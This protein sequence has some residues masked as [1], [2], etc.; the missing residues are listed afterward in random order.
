MAFVTQWT[1]EAEARILSAERERD[2][3]EEKAA[4]FAERLHSVEQVVLEQQ[5]AIEE[6]HAAWLTAKGGGGVGACTEEVDYLVA[7]VE[8]LQREMAAKT[9]E[10]DGNAREEFELLALRTRQAEGRADGLEHKIEELLAL[11]EQKD[12]Q[13]E[14]LTSATAQ[15]A[16]QAKRIAELEKMCSDRDHKIA[17]LQI[18]ASG[19][20]AAQR[21]QRV[22]ETEKNELKQGLVDAE[23]KIAEMEAITRSQLT[24]AIESENETL[25]KRLS[26]QLV[27][28]YSV[29]AEQFEKQYVLLRQQITDAQLSAR[30]AEHKAAARVKQHEAA[31]KKLEEEAAE[32]SNQLADIKK[33]S[34]D[35]R[36]G[37]LSSYELHALQQKLRAAE[38]RAIAA[39]TRQRESDQ[40]LE[41]T[42]RE[43][44]KKEEEASEA[45]R[46]RARAVE[47]L[48]AARFA[49]QIQVAETSCR[50][51]VVAQLQ[52]ERDLLHQQ[53]NQKQ[54]PNK[55]LTLLR[56]T[57]LGASKQCECADH[58]R[59]CNP[60]LTLSCKAGPSIRPQQ[61]T[62]GQAP[63][64]RSMSPPKRIHG[65]PCIPTT[66]M[67]AA[68]TRCI[69]TT[70]T[71]QVAGC[72]TPILTPVRH[73]SPP[74]HR[75][76]REASASP[77]TRDMSTTAPQ[78]PVSSRPRR[79]SAPSTAV[80][81][82]YAQRSPAGSHQGRWWQLP[83][84]QSKALFN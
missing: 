1:P 65:F 68:Q 33:A 35:R 56:A 8:R 83:V 59:L 14:V 51:A 62:L 22:L 23:A 16:A 80:A 25:Q 78:T 18:I 7:E 79:I 48:E 26:E 49:Q 30:S 54:F 37:K 24:T 84:V 20:D 19:V 21:E 82:A 72:S 31:I 3:A 40:E 77:R 57:H 53:L 10:L 28:E 34:P 81:P 38:A 55:D 32:H 6:M 12:R 39:E 13:V 63:R 44:D 47:A 9:A 2:K 76:P 42:R 64:S 11:I 29:L 36:L 60:T 61:R 50:L 75:E 45:L 73:L 69:N 17:K 41:I 74:P 70:E 27:K 43:A 5:D 71:I 52:A 15:V 46:E 58:S 66:Y 67:S 4:N